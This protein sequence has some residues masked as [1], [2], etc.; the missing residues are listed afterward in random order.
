MIKERGRSALER[1]NVDGKAKLELG[2]LW[3]QHAGENYRYFMVFANAELNGAMK[4]TD[5]LDLLG[6]L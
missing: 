1:R 2:K 5:F 6:P 3:E 4:R